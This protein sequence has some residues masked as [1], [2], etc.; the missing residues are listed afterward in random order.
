MNLTTPYPLP[1]N[2]GGIWIGIDFLTSTVPSAG[3]DYIF[4]ILNNPLVNISIW[5]CVDSY[6]NSSLNVVAD[7]IQDLYNISTIPESISAD[8]T[9]GNFSVKFIKPY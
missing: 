6:L 2:G 7:N 8:K 1:E 9:I 5:S 3:D 4:C